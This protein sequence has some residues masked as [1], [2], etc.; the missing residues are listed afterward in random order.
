MASR[1]KELMWGSQ[2]QKWGCFLPYSQKAAEFQEA[3]NVL[4]TWGK[5][6]IYSPACME[7]WDLI[8][9]QNES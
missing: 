3:M 4:S 9:L 5:R 1:L 7:P 8:T 6:S 2:T